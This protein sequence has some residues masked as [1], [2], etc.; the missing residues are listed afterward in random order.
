MANP[1]EKRPQDEIDSI[2]KELGIG[3]GGEGMPQPP[4]APASAPARQDR[5]ATFEEFSA[6]AQKN[7]ESNIALIKD[8]SLNV[9]VE[10]G[11]SKMLV[12]DILRLGPGSIVEL[13]KLTGDPL[14]LR[15]NDR[16]VAR[17]E[18]LVINDNFAIRITDVITQEKQEKP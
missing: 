2:M 7:V 11:R 16:L 14:D 4:S 8:V 9:K 12:Q 6:P 15:V 17:G 5:K 3:Q 18:I 1:E 13:D 10:L